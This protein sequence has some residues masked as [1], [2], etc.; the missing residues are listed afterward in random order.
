LEGKGYTKISKW[1]T[2]H[3]SALVFYLFRTILPFP[4]MQVSF[5]FLKCSENQPYI[6]SSSTC[7]TGTQLAQAVIAAF[8]LTLTIIS[9]LITQTYLLETNLWSGAPYSIFQSKFFILDC[10]PIFILPILQISRIQVY[11]KI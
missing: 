3:F 6:S 5:A 10:L 11:F 9:T 4:L 1:S 7:F 8:I 2:L